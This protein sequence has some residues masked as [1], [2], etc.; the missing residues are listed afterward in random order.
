MFVDDGDTLLIGKLRFEIVH[1]PGHSPGSISIYGE[2][3]VITGDTLFAGSVGRTDLPGGDIVKLR[4][5][6]RRL[7][8]LSDSIRVLPGHGPETTIGRERRENFFA[9]E[10]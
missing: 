8:S 1:T 10:L 5:S 4:A 2:G 9:S 3:I 7:M 6:F